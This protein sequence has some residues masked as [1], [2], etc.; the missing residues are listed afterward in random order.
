MSTTKQPGV[1][2]GSSTGTDRLIELVVS[3]P[4]ML[5]AYYRVVG[6]KSSAGVDGMT[7]DDLQSAGLNSPVISPY[8]MRIERDQQ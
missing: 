2:E 5:E 6:N 7:V 3:R 8:S 4:N 1:K